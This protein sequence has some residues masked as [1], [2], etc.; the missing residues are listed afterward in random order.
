VRRRTRPAA[1][2][3]VVLVLSLAA[4]ADVEEPAADVYEPAA[5]GEAEPSGV[6]AVTFTA[7][8]AQRVDLVTAPVAPGAPGGVVDHA[9]LIYDGKG[10]PW[11]Y[12]VTGPLRFRRTQVVVERVDGGVARLS[13]GPAPGTEVVT[14]GAAEV[15][16][17][18]LDIAGTH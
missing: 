7:E 9:A 11:V 12:S 18:E 4:C 17:A 1:A 16:G 6:K 13:A 14:V 2:A 3:L 8:A 5:L 10:V 15:Y